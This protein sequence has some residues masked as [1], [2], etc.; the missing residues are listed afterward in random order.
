M[1]A[2]SWV[3]LLLVLVLPL[4]SAAPPQPA[5]VPPKLQGLDAY[6]QQVMHDWR[7]PGLSLAVIQDG[8]V[9]L[10]RGYGVR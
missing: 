2:H 4:A 6:V 8:K 7:V 1:R 10:A 5:S 3:S 9:L